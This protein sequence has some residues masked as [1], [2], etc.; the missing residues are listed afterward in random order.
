MS[1][2]FH[3]VYGMVAAAALVCVLAAEGGHAAIPA[4]LL[5][6]AQ[7]NSVLP[8]DEF[9]CNGTIHGYV[10]F[11]EKAVHHH[12][13]EGI[14]TRPDGKIAAESKIPINF[15]PPGR[16]T[17]YV[18]LMFQPRSPGL[19]GG[20]DTS[21]DQ[22]RLAY[23]GRWQVEIRWDQKPLLRKNFVVACS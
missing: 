10:I 12:L 19:L 20:I 14:W 17:A 22:N 5:L 9:S 16:R 15:P 6:T 7:E 21:E 3:R 1:L 13:L 23:N 8:Q 4:T 18:W 11:P 2:V